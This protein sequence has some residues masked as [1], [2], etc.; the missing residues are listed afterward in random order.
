MPYKPEDVEVRV[1]TE[2]IRKTQKIRECVAN[3][4][5][6]SVERKGYV[7]FENRTL[8]DFFHDLMN[9]LIIID[10]KGHFVDYVD[11]YGN[12]IIETKVLRE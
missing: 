6:P 8:D 12:L 7:L 2:D 10:E 5:E 9:M 1:K 11:E 3:L 4:I